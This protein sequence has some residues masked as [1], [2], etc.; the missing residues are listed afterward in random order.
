ML[1]GVSAAEA[2][3]HHRRRRGGGGDVVRQQLTAGQSLRA[4]PGHIGMFDATIA[5]QV[6]QVRGVSG[7]D[8]AYPCAVLSGPGAVWLRSMPVNPRPV[9]ARE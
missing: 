1:G 3:P 8:D 5:I 6:T 9:P 2:P 4:H 7:R